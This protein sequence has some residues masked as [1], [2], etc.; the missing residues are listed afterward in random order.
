MTLVDSGPGTSAT[1]GARIYIFGGRLVSSRRMTNDLYELDLDTMVWRKIVPGSIHPSS[2]A[3]SSPSTSSADGGSAGLTPPKARYFHSADLWQGK[4]VFCG[5]MGYP[6]SPGDG[7]RPSPDTLGAA[8][9]G[10]GAAAASSSSGGSS[11]TTSG[12]K[13]EGLCV[14]DEVIALDLRTMRWELDFAAGPPGEPAQDPALMPEPRYAHLNSIVSEHLIIMGGQDIENK[15]VSSTNVFDLHKRRWVRV[16]PLKSQCGSYRSLAVAGPWIVKDE[17]GREHLA[18]AGLA[19]LTRPCW[20][21]AEDST[22]RSRSGSLAT[23]DGKAGDSDSIASRMRSGSTS[24]NPAPRAAGKDV[25]PTISL[26]P[27]PRSTRRSILSPRL[28]RRDRAS[29]SR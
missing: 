11:S 6:R 18:G 19:S 16:D 12:S 27:L 1:N 23:S 22:D 4:L 3:S 29:R 24:S 20:L 28:T 9:A 13:T 15:Y 7:T 26:H 21:P 8:A 2:S 14:L 25:E 10:A 5:G 17:D